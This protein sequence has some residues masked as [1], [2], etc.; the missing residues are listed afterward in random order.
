MQTTVTIDDREVMDLLGKLQGSMENMSKPMKQIGALM[1][2]EIH[3]KLGGGIT[4]W[5]EPM[6]PL[7]SRQGVPINDTRMHIYQRITYQ[8]DDKSVRIGMLDSETAKIGRVHQYG[9]IIKPVKA[10]RLVFT[11]RG[12]KKTYFAK[13]VTIPPRPFMPIRNERADLPADWTAGIMKILADSLPIN[14]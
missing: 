14:P 11:P 2:S 5:G 12:S 8:V 3:L 9:A 4:P 7:R 1:V 10:K 13:Q 6:K